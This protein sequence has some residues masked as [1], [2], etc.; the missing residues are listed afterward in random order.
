MLVSVGRLHA[1]LGDS[2]TLQQAKQIH[3]L[4][5]RRGLLGVP[6][7]G[8]IRLLSL[9]DASR[10]AGVSPGAV[11]RWPE[12]P[13]PYAATSNGRFWDA[14]ILLP[15]IEARRA[16]CAPGKRGRTRRE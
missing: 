1:V 11:S 13:E 16:G 15:V 6:D 14:K 5:R 8:Y 9:T 3:G 4:L 10:L 7:D 2:V 12:L